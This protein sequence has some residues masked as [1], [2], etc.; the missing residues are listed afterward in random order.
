MFVAGETVSVY[1]TLYAYNMHFVVDTPLVM[2]YKQS[3][4]DL[5]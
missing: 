3:I 1:I 5:T 2:G 4:I